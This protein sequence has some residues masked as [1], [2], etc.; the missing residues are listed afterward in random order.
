VLGSDFGRLPSVQNR[1]QYDHR[2]LADIPFL[3]LE[4]EVR[5]G[6]LQELQQSSLV[7]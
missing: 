2:I 6:S 7:K 4:I 5:Q 1:I 3:I